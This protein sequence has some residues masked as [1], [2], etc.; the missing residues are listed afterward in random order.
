MTR[1]LVGLMGL[2][3]VWVGMPAHAARELP[4]VDAF[5]S[6]PLP[7]TMPSA[8]E[9]AKG[10][11]VVHEEPRLGVPTFVWGVRAPVDARARKAA[12]PVSP[13]EAARAYLG[14]HR[15]LYRLSRADASHLP[16][17]GVH[18]MR[19]G[20]SI[21]TFAQ[22]VDGIEVFRQSLKVLL[23][24]DQQLI[25]MSGHLSPEASEPRG[26]NKASRFTLAPREA[27]ALAWRDLHGDPL[28]AVSL[29][30]TGR[31]QGPYSDYELGPGPR[32]VVF[33][34]PA[35]V[36]QVFFPMPGALAP[37]WYVELETTPVIENDGDH[38][39]YVISA[40]DGRV[41]YRHDLTSDQ[42]YSYRVWADAQSPHIPY[43]GPQGN[44]ATPHPTGL[45]DGYQH[46]FVPRNLVTLQN[47]PFSRNDPWLPAGATR[48]VGNNV[49]AY[50]DLVSPNGFSPGDLHASISA[51]GTFDHAY[52]LLLAPS[53]TDPQQMAAVTQ[54]FFV[55]NFL[56]DW[57]YDSGFDEASGNAQADNF[58]RGGLDG[59][60][61]RA[62]G[63]DFV[64]RNNANMS[65]PSDGAR[66]RMQMF[67][68]DTRGLRTIEFPPGHSIEGRYQVGVSA[69]GP[70]QY[71]ITAAITI[72]QDGPSG[73]END[74]EDACQ[75]LTNADAVRGRFALVTPGGCDFT[76]KA[77]H[78]QAAGAVGVL[79][80]DDTLP[81]TGRNTSITI[82]VIT[83]GYSVGAWLRFEPPASVR[84]QRD[85]SDRDGTL[86]NT[87]VAHEWMHYMSHR[88]VGNSNGLTNSQ[89][90]SMGE[91][92]GDFI[93]L[94]MVVR[95]GDDQQPANAGFNGVYARGAYV[96]SGGV[97]QGYYWG[98]RRYP[99]STDMTK[100][101]LT[102]RHIQDGVPL[103]A[104][105]PV[106][107][108]QDGADNSEVH[109]SGE[110]W[111]VTLWECYAALLRDESRL[112]FAQAQQR[113]KDYLVASLKLTP[114]APTFLEARDALLAV[115][116]A[117]DPAD[118]VL[119]AQAFAKRGAGTR[120]VAPPRESDD[121][122][123]VTE[124]YEHGKD[125]VLSSVEVLEQPG[126]PASCDDDGVFDTGETVRV[127][128]TLRNSGTGRLT[129]TSMTLSSSSPDL[130]FP[131]GA[132]VSFP[133]SEPLQLVSM[134]LPVR[135]SG[136]PGRRILPL[137]VSYRDEE[138]VIPGDRTYTLQ[139]PV[140]TDVL[141]GTSTHETADSHLHP[142]LL[143]APTQAF[144][145]PWARQV[146]PASAA[147]VFHGPDNGIEDEIS[148]VS[149]PLQVAQTGTFRFTFRHRYS[150][151][152]ANG[153]VFY[154]GA[155]I[156]LS[157]DDGTTW[158]DIGSA[159]SPTYNAVIAEG[160][161][162]PLENLPAYG[163]QSEGYPEYITATAEL[164]TAYAGKTVHIRFR[165]GTDGAVG[166]P[167]WD[168]DEIDFEG[169]VNTPFTSLVDHRGQCL[170]RAPVADAGSDQAVD[171]RSSVTLSGGGTDPEGA[172]LSYAWTQVVGPTVVLSRVSAQR[173]TFDAPEVTEDTDLRFELRVHDGV[174]TSAPAVV[175]VRVRNVVPPN[176]A[177]VAQVEA[178]APVDEGASVTLTGGAVDPDGDT[179]LTY[180]W[181]QVGSPSVTLT[182]ATTARASF[183]APQVDSD[184]EL[185]FQL[186]ASDGALE[187]APAVVTVLVRNV[188]QQNQAPVA[189]AGDD[190]RITEG[191]Q[192]RLTGAGSTDPEGTALTYTWSQV[193]GPTVSLSVEGAVATFT[194]PAVEADT[195][196]TFQLRVTDAL[197]ASS[198][199]TV[200][201][202][203]AN[204]PAPAPDSGCG[205]AAGQEGSVPSTVLMLLAAL[206]FALRR[207]RSQRVG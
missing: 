130:S 105:I 95:E 32:R 3:C 176:R 41:L 8:R 11:H 183:T 191:G 203:V 136:P 168:I 187:S 152:V 135:L 52:D 111:A 201:V 178:V 37:A 163:A 138:Q 206:G 117:N 36:R 133:A 13:E 16:V 25:A 181:T 70:Q 46:P 1:R 147:G 175:T 184:T 161:G 26:G 207:P 205:C 115:A 169:L 109:A 53:V 192:V 190:Q 101:P 120:A 76:V 196:L 15:E 93:G 146:D 195:V 156:E 198:E 62:E 171:E 157:E 110:M 33:S 27:I 116:L 155:V 4:P 85:G 94:L 64:G 90:R 54:M 125:V 186:V 34:S 160:G 106:R 177:P 173:P 172:T 77:A 149:P 129:R 142:W 99:Y 9:R 40:E 204:V 35:R 91:G 103:P 150:F 97:S 165:I 104:D 29:L 60:S 42:S 56:H 83:T 145:L 118:Y 21:V 57:F 31:V 154:D 10:V 102:L 185:T 86:D 143:T 96:N 137:T 66:P 194:A 5:A 92:W 44:A 18:R 126:S 30:P 123:G 28:P 180:A 162:N 132:T 14:E 128:V 98:S 82:P 182:D 200:T 51:P 131:A 114:N 55:T 67:Q 43:D 74:A 48:T 75:P 189:R 140:N 100:N 2:V 12:R 50:A 61:F 87:I 45:P 151:E 38:Y 89:G 19:A 107:Y 6:S 153:D 119:F 81:V 69:F 108:G 20:T 65:T 80:E 166:A 134:E 174:N 22:E 63:Q 170:N 68:Y 72:A 167:G 78:A 179:Q 112:T 193:D 49:E 73:P 113:M 144:N 199:D 159:L 164:G 88:L 24:E 79:I 39:A 84:L 139:L 121:H 158:R 59:D 202:S 148:L 127:R 124:S 122:I 71:D 7:K 47:V 17:R 141:P 188:V 58:G 197:G 23:D